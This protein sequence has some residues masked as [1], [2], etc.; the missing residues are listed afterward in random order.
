MEF[1]SELRIYS[2]ACLSICTAVLCGASI[3]HPEAGMIFLFNFGL[4]LA[5]TGLVLLGTAYLVEAIKRWVE[6]LSERWAKQNLSELYYSSLG[7]RSSSR[8]C[9]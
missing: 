1:W 6:S 4:G 8:R 9:L 7:F 3:A 5:A 2:A